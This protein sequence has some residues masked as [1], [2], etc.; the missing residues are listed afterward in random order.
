MGRQT[1]EQNEC[2][3]PTNEK[4]IKKDK[5]IYYVKHK[6]LQTIQSQ[7][8]STFLH[9]LH[10]IANRIQNQ[11]QKIK[12]PKPKKYKKITE[13]STN[14]LSNRWINNIRKQHKHNQPRANISSSSIGNNPN[15]HDEDSRI[16]AFR[17]NKSSL[18]EAMH[19][20]ST[21]APR[22]S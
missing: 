9:Q 1:Q 3:Y 22:G 10:N 4:N 21:R 20:I 6:P 11:I 15:Q 18:L 8:K 14:T 17:G 5:S 13:N 16:F 19:W 12:T 2:T 7:G